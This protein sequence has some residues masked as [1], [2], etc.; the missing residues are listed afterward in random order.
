MWQKSLLYGYGELEFE[1]YPRDSEAYLALEKAIDEVEKKVRQEP[2]SSEYDAWNAYDSIVEGVFNN[3]LVIVGEPMEVDSNILSER[4]MV[5]SYHVSFTDEF[6]VKH[7]PITNKDGE[8]VAHRHW[9]AVSSN[10]NLVVT[11]RSML[12]CLYQEG[13]PSG[14]A[15]A[16]TKVGKA[17][18][19][20]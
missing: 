5:V 3:V 10:N 14:Q 8:L 9:Y 20:A 17:D 19:K 15:Y 2:Y 16:K 12:E 6:A 18:K 11:L 1:P 7:K 13:V 4:R